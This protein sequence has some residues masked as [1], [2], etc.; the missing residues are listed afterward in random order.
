MNR[1]HFTITVYGDV[2]GVNFRASALN[3]ASQ[4]NV[5]GYVCNRKDGTVQI[6][7][8]GDPKNLEEFIRWCR[9]GPA[10]AKVN[11]VVVAEGSLNGFASFS[12]RRL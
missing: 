12:I 4:L 3:K 1:V 7:A 10:L 8:E 6:E 2:H 5:N 9:T 11:K